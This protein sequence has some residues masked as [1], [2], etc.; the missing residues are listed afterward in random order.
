MRLKNGLVTIFWVFIL[1]MSTGVS[2]WIRL[3]YRWVTDAANN[4]TDAADQFVYHLHWWLHV[5]EF[6]GVVFP[7]APSD[8]QLFTADYALYWFDYLAGY[9]V[10]LAEFGWNYSRQINVA[11]NRGAATIQNKDWGVIVTWTYNN[12]PYIGSGEELYD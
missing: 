6:R 9:D 10:V 4:I 11:L 8:F 2:I 12:P 1:G 7:Y 3:T 5:K